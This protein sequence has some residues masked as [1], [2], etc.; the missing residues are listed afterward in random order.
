[1]IAAPTDEQ[2]AIIAVVLILVGVLP[3][4]HLES[5]VQYDEVLLYGQLQISPVHPKKQPTRGS[6][7]LLPFP[8]LFPRPRLIFALPSHIIS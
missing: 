6:V 3:D 7:Q 4:G 1:M 5:G 2:A 8:Q